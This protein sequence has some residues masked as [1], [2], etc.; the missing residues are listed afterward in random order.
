M[1]SQPSRGLRR[2]D[3]ATLVAFSEALVPRDGD[4][5]PGA[6]E[7]DA[8]A[9]VSRFL[10]RVPSRQKLFVVAALRAIEW[11]S[12]PRPFSGL[13]L[14]ARTRRLERLAANPLGRDLLLGVNPMLTIVAMARRIA[15]GL[16]DQLAG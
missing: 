8:A 16:A 7:V 14:E 15:R 2:R 4:V 6:G 13:S 9:A 10:A 1:D 12:L 11:L 3:R 5:L